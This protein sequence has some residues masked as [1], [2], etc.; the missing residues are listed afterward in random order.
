MAGLA[1]FR[2]GPGSVR[3]VLAMA[4]MASH[5]SAFNIGGPAVMLFFIISGYWV[6]AAAGNWRGGPMSF[7][8][9]RALRIFPLFWLCCLL[10]LLV[11][12]VRDV[13]LRPDTP[14]G[15]ALLGQASVAKPL[16]SVDWSLDIELQFYLALPLL[17][18]AAQR[19]SAVQLWALTIVGWLLGIALA[20]MAGVHCV[21]L[22]MPAFAAGMALRLTAW[23][24]GPWWTTSSLL[25]AA[26]AAAGV[27]LLV[28]TAIVRPFALNSIAEHQGQMLW[29]LLLVPALAA[30]FQRPSGPVDRELGDCS[31]A[32]YLVHA[33]VLR[34][35]F[36]GLPLLLPGI[37]LLAMKLI[38][39]ALVLLATLALRRL[40]DRPLESWRRG[41]LPLPPRRRSVRRLRLSARLRPPLH[42][43]L[44]H[45]LAIAPLNLARKHPN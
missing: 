5:I 37:S 24:P 11:L 23:R 9:S 17:L 31:Y 13:P 42:A 14:Q 21:L 26:A 6:T 33:P 36:S 3:A 16:L 15:F 35:A 32:L 28:P 1:Q 30:L 44:V 29:A 25:A 43:Q 4:V 10:S 22:Y 40:V 38:G 45:T 8:A 12:F 18:A 41:L 27:A 7:V 39:V 34:L 19:W 20:V 2:P